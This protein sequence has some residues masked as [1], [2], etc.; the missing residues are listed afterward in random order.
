LALLLSHFEEER[1]KKVTI[2]EGFSFIKSGERARFAESEDEQSNESVVCAN[3]KPS[4][5]VVFK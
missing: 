3:E 5:I 1:T 2:H 4:V